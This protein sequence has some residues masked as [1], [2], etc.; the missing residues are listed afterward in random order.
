MTTT[1]TAPT[2]RRQGGSSLIAYRLGGRDYPLRTV[3]QCKVCSSPHRFEIE[4]EIAAGRVYKNIV[5]SLLLEDPDCD[6]T[7]KNLNDHYRNGH[8]PLEV[9][10]SRRILERRAEQR[11]LDVVAGVDSLVDGIALAE[12]V[13]QKTYEAV[14][15][16]EIKPDL[17]DG[18]YAARMLETFAPVE[19]GANAEIYA[20]AF[21]VYHEVAQMLMPAGQFEEFGR[22]LSANP[23]LKALVARYSEGEVDDG[24][25]DEEDEQPEPVMVASSEV[26]SDD[27]TP[28][29]VDNESDDD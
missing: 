10:A 7:N 4:K 13:V 23:T 5:A 6:L 20:Q 21:M 2:A 16:G 28:R 12:T 25:G 11:G 17:K 19:T 15:R 26:V 8:M 22:R 29:K 18:L 14:Q 9:E 24:D 1:P 3:A 27:T